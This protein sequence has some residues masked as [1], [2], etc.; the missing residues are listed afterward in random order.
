MKM[1]LDIT[2]K[3]IISLVLAILAILVLIQSRK[4]QTHNKTIKL[5]IV[6]LIA[7]FLISLSLWVF[8]GGRLAVLFYILLFIWP[9]MVILQERTKLTQNNNG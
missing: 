7:A 9:F 6:S 5:A 3:I 4:I 8:I 1:D 2:Y